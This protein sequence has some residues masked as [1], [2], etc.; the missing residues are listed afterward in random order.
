MQ[1]RQFCAIQRGSPSSTSLNFTWRA[2]A[3][4]G[5]AADEVTRL[6][7]VAISSWRSAPWSAPR[8][9]QGRASLERPP[10]STSS[11]KPLP[12]PSPPPPPQKLQRLPLRT[13]TQ[14]TTTS[15]K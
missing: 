13:I 12:A 2:A 6:V 14:Y 11:S 9:H 15:E 5:F 3:A 8:R 10:A 7:D 4:T 1:P